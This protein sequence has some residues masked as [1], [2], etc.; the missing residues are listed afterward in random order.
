M[1]SNK[2][3]E[4]M[5]GED[6]YY[7]GTSA[8]HHLQTNLNNYGIRFDSLKETKRK[9]EKVGTSLFMDNT[10][11]RPVTVSELKRILSK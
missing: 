11:E 9:I 8:R 5:I 4:V 7:V 10:L 2:V 6:R 3:F 1:E